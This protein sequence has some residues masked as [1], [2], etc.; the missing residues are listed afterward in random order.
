MITWPVAAKQF[1]NEKLVIEVIKIGVP[2]GVKK[3]TRFIGDDSVKWDALE[4][5]VKMVMVE[6]M[7]NRAQVFKQMARRAVEEGGSSDSNLD[8][9]VREL[10]SLSH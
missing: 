5:A 1:Y 7:R 9:L 8:A 10:C 6:E 4:K 3:W 2:V